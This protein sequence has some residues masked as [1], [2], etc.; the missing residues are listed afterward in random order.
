M[1]C[2]VC[3]MTYISKQQVLAHK[4]LAERQAYMGIKCGICLMSIPSKPCLAN[5]L[6]IA[7]KISK[8]FVC[9]LIFPNTKSL[10]SHLNRVK[11][12]EGV[13]NGELKM[14]KIESNQPKVE[15]IKVKVRKIGVSAEKRAH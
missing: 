9:G 5:H 14:P 10:L 6:E 11:C 2:R 3:E 4:K 15:Q 7:H 8:C 13:C 12:L 1:R